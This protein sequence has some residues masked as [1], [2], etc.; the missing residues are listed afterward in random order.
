MT[1]NGEALWGE[2]FFI[3]PCLGRHITKELSMHQMRLA[4]ELE[5]S[6]INFG[7]VEFLAVTSFR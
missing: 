6:P 3:N 4:N 1:T 2:G 5:Q 7:L